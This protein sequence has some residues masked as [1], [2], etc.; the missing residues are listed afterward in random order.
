[1]ASLFLRS[2]SK[3]QTL[4]PLFTT[5]SYAVVSSSSPQT[6]HTHHQ[7]THSYTSPNEFLNSWD[8]P[9][10]PKEANWKLAMLRRQ[11]AK[12]VKEVRKEYIQDMELQRI[13]KLRKDEA[14]KEALRVANEE[15][16]AAKL[17]AKKVK[18]AQR[19]VADEDFR[20]MLI[21]ERTEKLEYW[22]KRESLVQEKKEK[23]KED[24]RRQSSMWI[25]ENKLEA[26]TLEA[27]VDGSNHF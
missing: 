21:K 2:T 16:K 15:R 13:D 4:K 19:M 17:E 7:N 3:P 25:D 6:H 20:K 23:K 11:Y 24:L 5:R 26:R 1:M 8:P 18:A 12:Q 22:K 10:N 9:K 27:L 14:K